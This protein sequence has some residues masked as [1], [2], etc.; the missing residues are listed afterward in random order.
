MPAPTLANPEPITPTICNKYWITNL[1]LTPAML[2]ATLRPFDGANVLGN[3]S[4]AKRVIVDPTKDAAAAAT[5]AT[6]TA[7]IQGIAGKTA[8]VTLITVSEADPRAA[9]AVL[10]LFAD[11]S[12]HRI[13]DLFALVGSNSQAA[14]AFA[15]LITYLAT[16]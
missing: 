15:A 4:L 11:K 1:T 8:A 16:K 12:T 9:T 10:A 2:S 13:A 7:A 5:I 14:G 3:T 6:I